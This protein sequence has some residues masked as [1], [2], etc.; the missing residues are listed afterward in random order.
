MIWL[1]LFIVIVQLV[2][3]SLLANEIFR[4]RD[5]LKS[6]EVSLIALFML[7][8]NAK[9]SQ[10]GVWFVSRD[11]LNRYEYGWVLE[12]F[13]DGRQNWGTFIDRCVEDS[14]EFAEKHAKQK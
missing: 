11:D 2:A 8:R 9:L 5:N 1:L 7:L 4:L 14:S 10:S 13:L 12:H 3:V 6:R